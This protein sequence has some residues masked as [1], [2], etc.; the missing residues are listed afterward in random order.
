MPLLHIP[1]VTPPYAMICYDRHGHE[2]Q[3]DPDGIAGFLGERVLEA[4]RNQPPS[5]V[6]LFLHGWKGH[7]DTAKD[8]YDRWI[9]SFADRAGTAF[10]RPMY[11]ALHWPSMPWGDEELEREPCSRPCCRLARSTTSSPAKSITL[12]PANTSSRARERPA[13][14]PISMGRRL[15]MSFY[16][17]RSQDGDAYHPGAASLRG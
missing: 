4:M 5:D 3:N 9:R 8:R 10:P 14:T 1:G 6:F 15:R 12:K 11:I 7:L 17:Q 13:P 2:A 16:M